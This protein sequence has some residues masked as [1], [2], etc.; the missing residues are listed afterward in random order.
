M[1][2]TDE[3]IKVIKPPKEQQR[4]SEVKLNTESK[5]RG[6]GIYILHVI[7]RKVAM[8]FTKVGSNIKEL[9]QKKIAYEIEGKCAVEGYIKKDSVRVISY[10]SGIL[11]SSEVLFDVVLECLVCNPVEGM[12]MRVFVENITKAGIRASTGENSP[13]DVFI[14]RDHHFNSKIFSKVQ[15]GDEIK[16]RVIGQRYEINDD[17]ISVIAELVSFETKTKPGVYTTTTKKGMVLKV[18]NK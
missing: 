3:N 17:K 7:H 10:S 18:G 11:V 16:V 6:L 13:V 14:A 1:E 12:N 5:K 15:V 8:P 4:K 2:S 9:I